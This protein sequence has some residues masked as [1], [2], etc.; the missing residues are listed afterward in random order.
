MGK[1]PGRIVLMGSGELTGTMV[2]LHKQLLK[3]YGSAARAVFIDTPAGFQLNVDQISQKA[4]DYFKTRVQ[5]PLE[6][7]SFKSALSANAFEIETAYRLI[8][9]ADYILIGP[10][11]PTYAVNHWKKSLIPDLLAKR[12]ESGGCLVAAS[13]A[14]LTVGRSAL[15]VYE[16]YKVG[17]P[18]HWTEGIDILGRWGLNMVVVPHWNNAEG[19]N[20][21]TR[22]C[23]MGASRFS[24][25][26]DLLDDSVSILGLD[27]HTALV[28]DL[29]A[30]TATVKGIG[31]TILRRG[32]HERIFFKNES[33]PLDVLRGQP[34]GQGPVMDEV[35]SAQE[36]VHDKPLDADVWQHLHEI[37]NHLIEQLEND[38]I[39]QATTALLE[40]ESSIWKSQQVL[41]ETEA[42]GAA[43]QLLRELLALL[44]H[45]AAARPPSRQ[46]CLSPLV[47]G[48]LRL[49]E[50]LRQNKLWNEAD[51]VR[52]CLLAAGVVVE[53]TPQGPR[54][55]S[56]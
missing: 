41:Q 21:D 18:L 5:Q 43:R 51:S 35:L 8:R 54:W 37:E 13:A 23:F 31:K 16:I 49:R 19:G 42:M 32:P 6:I 50:R 47:Q 29:A 24:Q 38:Q 15:P 27:E 7:A 53:D 17:Q 10:G 22:F 34:M 56:K 14:A 55:Y 45:K 4:I 11:S 26:R 44:G 36:V 52:D 12:V 1:N 20:H 48:L 9:Q 3:S 30:Q 40:L 33:I 25:L 46:E 2:E 28:I 39:E